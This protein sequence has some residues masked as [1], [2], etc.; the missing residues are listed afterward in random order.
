[1]RRLF[2]LAFVLT[3]SS[4]FC[5][6]TWRSAHLGLLKRAPRRYEHSSSNSSAVIGNNPECIPRL[7]LHLFCMFTAASAELLH[8]FVPH[9]IKLG[10]K[11]ES[12]NFV[13]NTHGINASIA[14]STK[15]LLRSI[16][17]WRF[18]LEPAE[19]TSNRKRDIVNTWLTGLPTDAWVI[20]ADI[21]EF[22]YY[23]K[24]ID[25]LIDLGHDDFTGYMVDQVDDTFTFPELMHSSSISEQYPMSCF[26]LRQRISHT[27]GVETLKHVL[28]RVRGRDSNYTEPRQF[29]TS[30]KLRSPVEALNVGPFK[31]FGFTGGVN[32]FMG[33]LLMKLHAYEQGDER[34]HSK[35]IGRTML[36]RRQLDLF[37]VSGWPERLQLTVSGSS[38][39]KETCVKIGDWSAFIN[40]EGTVHAIENRSNEIR[41]LKLKR[42]REAKSRRES[43]VGL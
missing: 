30:H 20:Y 7:N 40:K 18:T 8:H 15:A 36:Y 16:N 34:G 13:V 22:F 42:T 27:W 4:Y 43:Y 23:P 6:L 1:M 21:D 10:V 3:F 14:R 37:D 32:G 12:M 19:F 33:V 35:N 41:N 11:L 29:S 38:T 24:S 39:F 2:C 9:Y 31:H 25:V 5:I 17:V 28:F 26:G